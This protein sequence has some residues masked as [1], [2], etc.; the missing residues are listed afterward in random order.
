MRRENDIGRKKLLEIIDKWKQ[1]EIQIDS[2]EVQN[3]L[4]IENNRDYFH[5]YKR[6]LE[7]LQA[8]LENRLKKFERL[9]FKFISSPLLENEKDDRGNVERFSIVHSF[10]RNQESQRG[11]RFMGSLGDT[12]LNQ[13][14]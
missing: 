13:I 5:L 12:R 11:P 9:D 8:I 7:A 10:Q 14:L 6:E 2:P 3:L 4:M 1:G